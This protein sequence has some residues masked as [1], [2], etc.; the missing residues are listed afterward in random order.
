MKPLTIEELKA[1]EV[2]DWVWVI[3]KQTNTSKYRQ[4][5]FMWADGELLG[6]TRFEFT[7]SRR[8]RGFHR[9][10]CNYG[11]SWLAYKNKEQAEA[12]GEIVE[13]PC[14]VGDTVYRWLYGNYDEFTVSKINFERT[15]NEIDYCLCV[16]NEHGLGEYFYKNDEGYDW[17][18]TKESVER[19]LAELKGEEK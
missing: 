12:K 7:S 6:E 15:K 10:A 17:F 3:D 1:L 9:H 18:L 13:L 19:R 5:S 4:L 2:G 8:Q 14:K 16:E 11:K